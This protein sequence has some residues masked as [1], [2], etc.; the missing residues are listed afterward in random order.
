VEIERSGDAA[1]KLADH[2]S[3][4]RIDAVKDGG[5]LS[6]SILFAKLRMAQTDASHRKRVRQVT[7]LERDPEPPGETELSVCL[8]L[9]ESSTGSGIEGHDQ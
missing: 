5:E 7:Q 9:K 3:N 4:C 2:L 1:K 8:L 6:A